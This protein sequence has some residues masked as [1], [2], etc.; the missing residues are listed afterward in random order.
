ME[1]LTVRTPK[2]LDVGCGGGI[3]SEALAARIFTVVDMGGALR[4]DHSYRPAWSGE[5]VCAYISK[6]AGRRF[7]LQVNGD[8][9]QK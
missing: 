5:K 8:L 3:L 2:I 4:S 6:Q 1:S 9:P 7:A